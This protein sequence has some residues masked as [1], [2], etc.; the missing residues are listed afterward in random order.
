MAQADIVT[1]FN[2]RV[3]DTEGREMRQSK[4]KASR[5]VVLGFG[6]VVLEGTSQVVFPGDLD[7][8]GRYRRVATGWGALP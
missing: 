7:E 8:N 6:G 2:F 1:V 3:F 5:A 4:F